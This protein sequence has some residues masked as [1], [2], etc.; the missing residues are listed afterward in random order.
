[1]QRSAG[2]AGDFLNGVHEWL[3]PPS[4]FRQN[5]YERRRRTRA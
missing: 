2:V 1:L 4:S 5:T 3:R